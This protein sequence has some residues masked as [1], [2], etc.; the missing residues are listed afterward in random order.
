M[1]A[2]ALTLLQ[3]L[4]VSA[5]CFCNGKARFGENDCK[6]ICI[7]YLRC[8]RRPDQCMWGNTH[9]H[10]YS[11]VNC[12]QGRPQTNNGH[13]TNMFVYGE[14]SANKTE[15]STEKGRHWVEAWPLAERWCDFGKP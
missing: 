13:C 15:N 2:N 12:F 11:F 3:V 14:E 4:W 9:V 7:C 8:R 6:H 5:A 1:T 10:I